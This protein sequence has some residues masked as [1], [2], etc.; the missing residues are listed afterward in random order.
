MIV[1]AVLLTLASVAPAHVVYAPTTLREWV[2]NADLIAVAEIVAPLRVWRAA[3]GSDLQEYLS[4]HV[5]E[6]LRGTTPGREI[7]YFPH[8]EGEPRYRP[9]DRALLFLERTVP[10]RD[11][12]AVA[13]RFPYFSRQGAGNEWKLDSADD[14][15]LEMARAW[16]ALPKDAA[17]ADARALLLRQLTLGDARLQR[18]AIFELVRFRRQPGAWPDAAAVEP[19]ARLTTSAS[20][21]PTERIALTRALDGAP[22][23]DASAPLLALTGDDLDAPTRKALVSAASVSRDPRLSAWLA[24]QLESSDPNRRR[25]AA[26]ALAHPWHAAHVAKLIDLAVG[27]ADEDVARSAVRALAAID[28][29]ASRT[30]LE[31]VTERRD[32]SVAVTARRLLNQPT[33][34]KPRPR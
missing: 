7:D 30:G 1:V 16:E 10:R 9:G 29:P 14:P 26:T 8:A 4:V 33:P 24:A 23:F 27:D 32:D 31:A 28:D 6:V 17:A 15:A 18:D 34:Q 22:G 3:D 25:E 19:F 12:V 5:I 13:A 20:L 21:G 11:R 2:A